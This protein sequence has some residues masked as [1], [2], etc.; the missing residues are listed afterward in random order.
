MWEKITRDLH[1][2]AIQQ[3]KKICIRTSEDIKESLI[4][5]SNNVCCKYHILF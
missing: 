2:K 4:V 5:V 1:A 3:F